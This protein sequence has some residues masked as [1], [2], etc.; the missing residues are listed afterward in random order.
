MKN[1]KGKKRYNMHPED[2]RLKHD[3]ERMGMAAYE[4]ER[5]VKRGRKEVKKQW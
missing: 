5:K 1:G 3:D 4:D 2:K